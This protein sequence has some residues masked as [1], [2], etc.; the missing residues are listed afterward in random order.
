MFTDQDSYPSAEPGY[1]GAN[2]VC[3]PRRRWLC[4]KDGYGVSTWARP[5]VAEGDLYHRLARW[6][7]SMDHSFGRHA[8]GGISSGGFPWAEGSRR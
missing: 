7:G 1:L 8:A 3:F 2:Y 6:L 4:T 5:V